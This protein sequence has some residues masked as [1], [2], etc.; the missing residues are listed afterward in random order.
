MSKSS[1]TNIRSIFAVLLI[2]L[3]VFSDKPSVD[4]KLMEVNVQ[5]F[6]LL[7]SVVLIAVY[8]LFVLALVLIARSQFKILKA[9]IMICVSISSL[10]ADVFYYAS[11]KVMEY[12]DFVIL[13][14]SRAN[15]FDAMLMYHNEI[16]ASLVRLCA[17]WAGFIIMPKVVGLKHTKNMRFLMTSGGGG[18]IIAPFSCFCYACLHIPTRCS[19]KQASKS[20]KPTS[21]IFGLCL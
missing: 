6:F 7:K 11:G 2:A 4:A 14:Q 17:L 5:T 19:D 18:Y 21:F 20:A 15:I 9:V 3:F 8:G 12:I 13:Y 16:M 10:Y 1:Y